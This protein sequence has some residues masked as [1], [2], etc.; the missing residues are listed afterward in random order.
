MKKVLITLATLVLAATA[1]A[2]CGKKDD[3]KFE[4]IDC[5][6]KTIYLT[7]HDGKLC[8]Y[9]GGTEVEYCDR[10]HAIMHERGTYIFSMGSTEI[11]GCKKCV[12]EAA[13]EYYKEH[14]ITIK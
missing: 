14:N 12:D 7:T 11:Q 4:A 9:N 1:L 8:Y 6:G 5:E 13:Q 2:S 10:C 3:N